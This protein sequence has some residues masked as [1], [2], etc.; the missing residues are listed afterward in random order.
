LS[1]EHILFDKKLL[2]A[3]QNAVFNRFI[4]SAQPD[5]KAA[6]VTEKFLR[7]CNRHGVTTETMMKIIT[8]MMEEGVFNAD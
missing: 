2:I 3:A 6:E 7:C 1:E 4:V 8:D 5:E